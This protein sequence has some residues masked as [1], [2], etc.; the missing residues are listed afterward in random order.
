MLP[1]GGARGAYQV[2]VFR[3]LLEILEPS[4]NPFPIITG[5]SAG[6]I[7]AAVLASHAENLARGTDRLEHFWRTMTCNR[8]YRT[9]WRAVMSSATHWVG[10]LLFGRL[11]VPG[12]VSLLSTTPLRQLLERETQLGGIPRAIE[13]RTLH[14]VAVTSSGYTSSRALAFFDGAEVVEGWERARRIGRRTTIDV[15]HLMASAALPVLFPP[16]RVGNEWF[17]D[18]GLR[19]TAPLSP[20]IH[21]GA[22]RIL[23]ITTRDGHPDPEPHHLERIPTVGDVGGYLLDILFLD[24]LDADL[25]RL[26]RINE[27]LARLSPEVRADSPLRPIETLVL[28]P[29]V[30]LRDVADRHMDRMPR[31]VRFL[32]AGVGAWRPGTRLPSYLLFDAAYCRDLIEL[33]KAD[34]LAH[35]DEVLAFFR[36]ARVGDP[37]VAT[38]RS[39]RD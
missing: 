33:G 7:N 30:D 3:G 2:G 11:G 32:L 17:G 26:K 24:N 36:D 12:P 37:G 25:A 5:T 14:G 31:S 39:E 28:R 27:T 15:D 19:M 6:A 18:G 1:G 10:S 23:V 34:A 20:A 4:G 13:S 38:A 9:D 22:D 16:V 35:R 29:S 8:I 21:L